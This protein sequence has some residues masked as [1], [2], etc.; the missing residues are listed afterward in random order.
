M[1]L[2][3]KGLNQGTLKRNKN[4]LCARGNLAENVILCFKSK[5][6]KIILSSIRV[7]S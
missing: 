6:K 1:I 5:K 2:R 4:N 7:T 3:V